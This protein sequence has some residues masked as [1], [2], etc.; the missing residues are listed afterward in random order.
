MYDVSFSQIRAFERT[1]RLGGVQVAAKSLGLTQPA[2]SLRIREL[3]RVL[4]TTVFHR[5][6]RSLRLTADGAAFLVYADQFLRTADEMAVRLTSGDPINGILRLGVIQSFA[7]VCL[8]PLMRRLNE[9]YGDVKTSIYVGDSNSIS[10]LLN[11][12][13]L[14]LAVTSEFKI[15]GYI[16]RQKL[17]VNRHGWFAG[18]PYKIGPNVSVEEISTHH[19]IVTPPPSQHYARILNW[20]SQANVTPQRI[21]TCNDP[22]STIRMVMSGAGLACLSTRVM[23]EYVVAG[24]VRELTVPQPVPGYEVWVCYQEET[25]RSGLRQVVDMIQSTITETQIY[26]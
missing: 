3:E 23:R 10:E 17:G 26:V 22:S 12:Q 4:G 14:D 9:K 6:G 21:S 7:W 8:E 11:D 24:A 5:S 2:V 13:K 1:V 15:A 18:L 20:F 16:H 19:L 25:L